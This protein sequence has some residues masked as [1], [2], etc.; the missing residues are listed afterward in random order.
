MNLLFII[1]GITNWDYYILYKN[2]F[3]K[4]SKGSY[5]LGNVGDYVLGISKIEYE[6][7]MKDL[8]K[9][10]FRSSLNTTYEM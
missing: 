4:K 6:G 10:T 7:S 2:K 1:D 5:S 9:K 3:L 8:Y